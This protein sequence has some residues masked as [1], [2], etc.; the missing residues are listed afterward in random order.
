MWHIRNSK[1]EIR[2]SARTGGFTLIE[3][4][5]AMFILAIGLVAI[6]SI[7]PVSSYIQ[8]QTFNE[9]MTLQ[10]KRNAESILASR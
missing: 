4:L 9:T 1:F 5:M 7:F 3:L 6:A 10:I 2:N 8:K